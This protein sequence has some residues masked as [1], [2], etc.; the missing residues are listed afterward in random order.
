M[1]ANN[2]YIVYKQNAFAPSK[3]Y[4]GL[5]QVKSLNNFFKNESLL[6]SKAKNQTKIPGY[7]EIKYIKFLII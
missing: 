7:A 4:K 2:D 3:E 5:K 6:Y 1:K